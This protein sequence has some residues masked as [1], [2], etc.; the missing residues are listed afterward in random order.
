MP[1]ILLVDDDAETC[2]FLE[3]LL[4]AP[5][6]QFVSVHDS[7]TALTTI[8]NDSFDLLISDI[9]LNEPRTGIDLLRRFK[10]DQGG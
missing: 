10:A 4:D 9:N 7:D 6:R 5:D 8:R 3:E 2:K 1:R